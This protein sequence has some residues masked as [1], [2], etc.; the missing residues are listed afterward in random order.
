MRWIGDVYLTSGGA[1]SRDGQLLTR[2]RVSDGTRVDVTP[3]LD[4]QIE[5]L[6]VNPEGTLLALSAVRNQQEDLWITDMD[7]TRA[8]RLTEDAAFDRFPLWTGSTITFRRT[9][10]ARSTWRIN[11]ASLTSRAP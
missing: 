5:W 10:A 6:D 3:R 7:G 2:V 9:G 8:R 11:P 4:L 1:S